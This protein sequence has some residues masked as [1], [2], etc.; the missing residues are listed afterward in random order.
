M[1]FPF[2]KPTPPTDAGSKGAIDYLAGEDAEETGLADPA[3]DAVHALV[4]K[5]GLDAVKAAVEKCGGDEQVEKPED[6][7]DEAME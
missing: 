6:S 1:P 2:K 5:F 4:V 7:E 3:Y